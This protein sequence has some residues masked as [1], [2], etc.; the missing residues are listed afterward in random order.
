MSAPRPRARLLVALAVALVASIV[1]V[2]AL[3]QD[4]PRPTP[5]AVDQSVDNVAG[6]RQSQVVT[7]S[8]LA[9]VLLGANEQIN[10]SNCVSAFG[11][12]GSFSA[13][14]HGRYAL[15]D[16]LTL[17]GGMAYSEY[18]GHDFKVTNAPI[19]AASLRYDPADW[20][21]S[22]PFGEVGAVLTPSEDL[23]YLR[24]YAD[25]S[26]LAYGIGTTNG[27]NTIIFGRIG[28]VFR[29]S[30]QDEVAISG[31]ISHGWQYV[32]G[33]SEAENAYNPFSA[34]VA[35]GT[36]RMNIAEAGA[37]WTHLFAG[38]IEVNLNA[39]LAHSFDSQSGLSM[40][41]VG[42]G[43]VLPI[44]PERGWLEYGGRISYRLSEAT[45]VDAFFDGAAG[46]QPIGSS[47]HGGL[48]LR[49]HF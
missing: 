27:S 44:L 26:R 38:K 14:L 29:L 43:S 34:T 40:N 18:D 21:K 45:V 4:E 24:P 5:G 30:G 16:R 7:N 32:N 36:D 42:F 17:L 33:Y 25:G 12:V 35:G 28:W 15:T 37:Q 48:G 2:P 39:G 8:V 49:Y 47:I 10:C 1:G 46:P 22:R 41:V 20:G 6:A 31:K 3:A 23:R 19:F 9:S 11:S 13:G